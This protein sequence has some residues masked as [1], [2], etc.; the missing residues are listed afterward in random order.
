MLQAIGTLFLFVPCLA[1]LVRKQAV[2]AEKV[3]G[4]VAVQLFCGCRK[5]F[6]TCASPSML[7]ACELQ[8]VRM[9]ALVHDHADGEV[10]P[11]CVASAC[12]VYVCDL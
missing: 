10:L 4:A 11:M 9:A 3:V 12:A 5:H 8:S 6:V 7:E 2:P 1:Q